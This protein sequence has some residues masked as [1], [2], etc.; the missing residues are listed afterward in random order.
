MPSHQNTTSMTATDSSWHEVECTG[1]R[2]SYSGV[3][4]EKN[5]ADFA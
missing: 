4:A 1:A 2:L 3:A 5:S